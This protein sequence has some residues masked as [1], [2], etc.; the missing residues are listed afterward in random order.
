MDK[1]AAGTVTPEQI[2]AAVEEYMTAHPAAGITKTDAEKIVEDYVTAHKAEL[3]G[4]KGETGQTGA[5][6]AP[7][8]KGADGHKPVRGVDYWT[9]DDISTIQTYIDSQIGG[10]LNGSY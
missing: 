5:T 3:K 6:G 10:V 2:A 7:G 9:A 1:L 8:E 4:D